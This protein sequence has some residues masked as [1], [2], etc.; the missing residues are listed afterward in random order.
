MFTPDRPSRRARFCSK[1]CAAMLS[2]RA[3]R[4]G[5]L[6]L[7]PKG[8]LIRYEPENPMAT[9]Q[10]MVLEHRR[11]MGEHLGR[12]L[13][14]DEIVHHRNEIKDDNR[15]ENLELMPKRRHDRLPKPKAKPIQCPHCQG[16]IGVSNP[17]R[18]VAPL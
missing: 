10:G 13:T 14:P 18:V 7:T 5:K 17:V 8:Y 11:V 9:K 3:R 12:P 6:M 1:R 16:M 15:I 2:G 4:T